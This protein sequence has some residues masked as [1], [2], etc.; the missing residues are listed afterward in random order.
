MIPKKIHYCWF[1]GNPLPELALKCIESWKKFCPE[2]EIIEW[3]EKNFNININQYIKEAYKNKKW[4]FVTDYVRLEVLYK[5]GGIYLDTDVELLRNL[6]DLLNQEAFT[7]YET[8]LDIPTGII[9]SQKGNK[10]IKIFLDDYKNRKFIKWNGN[11][12]LTTNVTTIT[13]IATDKLGFIPEKG[14]Q[15]LEYG[16]SIYPKDYFCPKDYKTKEIVLTSNTYMIHHFNGS[17]LESK[18]ER[19]KRKFKE[20]I[21]KIGKILLFLLLLSFIAFIVKY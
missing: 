3:N 6:D 15:I 5:Y 7:G 14:H 4:A 11:F 10:A 20:R 13:K 9:A 21:I 2:Y 17:W 8:S 19:K 1:G 18:E 12:D 16:L